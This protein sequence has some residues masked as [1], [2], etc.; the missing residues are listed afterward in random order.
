MFARKLIILVSAA[1]AIGAAGCAWETGDESVYYQ[2]GPQQQLETDPSG[3]GKTPNQDVAAGDPVQAGAAQKPLLAPTTTPQM[4]P[5]PQPWIG[6]GYAIVKP[7]KGN[8]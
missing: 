8:Q 3:T 4:D 2:H 5:E 7:P 6:T 1:F